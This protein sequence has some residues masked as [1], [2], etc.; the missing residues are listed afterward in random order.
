LPCGRQHYLWFASSFHKAVVA[1]QVQTPKC[2]GLGQLAPGSCGDQG[3]GVCSCD[4]IGLPVDKP[5]CMKNT[6]IIVSASDLSAVFHFSLMKNYT[7]TP[8]L[9]HLHRTKKKTT[10]TTK[11]I[12]MMAMMIM[13]MMMLMMMMMMMMMM[14]ISTLLLSPPLLLLELI[15][16]TQCW[17]RYLPKKLLR[18]IDMARKPRR[19][20]GQKPRV[21]TRLSV[22]HP[23]HH[24]PL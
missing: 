12:L 13:M 20:P 21:K 24:H 18:V 6:I 14:M 17:P 4:G 23:R 2:L 8:S 1:V 10:T 19:G 16:R 7:L 3:S 15:K 22:L 9:T 5:A 11:M